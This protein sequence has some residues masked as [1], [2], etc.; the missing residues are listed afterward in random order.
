MPITPGHGRSRA[1]VSL[2][3]C[4][5]DNLCLKQTL[6]SSLYLMAKLNVIWMKTL[7][8]CKGLFLGMNSG[9][10]FLAFHVVLYQK[11]PIPANSGIML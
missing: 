5:L 8:I 9:Y 2:S 6:I 4:E 1:T 3:Q 10:R 11:P 7:Y